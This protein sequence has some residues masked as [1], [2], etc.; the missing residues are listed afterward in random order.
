M[1]AVAYNESFKLKIV[2]F[3]DTMRNVAVTEGDKVEAEI[4]LGWTVD[5]WPVGDLVEYVDAVDEKDIDA[6]Y[7][8]LEE[9]YEMVEGDNDH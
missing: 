7:Q 8:K 9:Q 1:V 4:R 2:R 6:E 3:G 5:Y